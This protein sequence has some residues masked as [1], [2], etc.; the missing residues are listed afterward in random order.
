[1][2]NSKENGLESLLKEGIITQQEFNH[3]S[4]KRKSV[5]DKKQLNI[6]FCV[7]TLLLPL[8]AF[9]LFVISNRYGK[10]C[11]DDCYRPYGSISDTITSIIQYTYCSLAFINIILYLL[12]GFKQNLLNGI[13]VFFNISLCCYSAMLAENGW[14]FLIFMMGG[15]VVAILHFV[16]WCIIFSR[17]IRYFW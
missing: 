4:Q 1:M 12:K 5:L 9:L 7:Y 17:L 2:A 15:F 6:P 13:S 10:S 3:L 14:A 8:I 16:I 11:A